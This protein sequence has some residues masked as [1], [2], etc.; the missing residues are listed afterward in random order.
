MY[1]ENN[2]LCANYRPNKRTKK[3]RQVQNDVWIN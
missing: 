2:G 3:K 1:K